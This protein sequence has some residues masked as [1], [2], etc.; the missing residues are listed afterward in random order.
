[1]F[2]DLKKAKLAT[3]D[4]YERMLNDLAYLMR[5]VRTEVFTSGE[6]RVLDPLHDDKPDAVEHYVH[7]FG[8]QLADEGH[9]YG[10]GPELSRE[11]SAA[12]RHNIDDETVEI[13]IRIVTDP[14][15]EDYLFG[16]NASAL[17]QKLYHRKIVAQEPHQH[18]ARQFVMRRAHSLYTNLLVQIGEA[19]KPGMITVR[20]RQNRQELMD[21][22][23]ATQ[24]TRRR[25][26]YRLNYERY[27]LLMDELL[28][29]KAKPTKQE[30]H[31]TPN[32]SASSRAPFLRV[33]KGG[34]N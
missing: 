21:Q 10:I 5:H 28:R 8:F 29:P 34:K 6:Y 2:L 30:T 24:A 16:M 9:A 26:V 31:S 25:E 17:E 22:R 15:R 27:Q 1:M 33:I 18:F 3:Q 19:T 14:C 11:E 4:E 32:T 12:M 20:A 13:L 23:A 7:G